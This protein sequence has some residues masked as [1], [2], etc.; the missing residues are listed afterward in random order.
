MVSVCWFFHS[1][2]MICS[3]RLN[4]M[5]GDV[6]HNERVVRLRNKRLMEFTYNLSVSLIVFNSDQGDVRFKRS[7]RE[8]GVEKTKTKKEVMQ[9]LH[10]TR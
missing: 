6:T 8:N 1:M 4:R 2:M 10:G 9:S 5:A 7:G 3:F